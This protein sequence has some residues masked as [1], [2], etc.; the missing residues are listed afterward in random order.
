M[1]G[2]KRVR[3]AGFAYNPKTKQIYTMW[4]NMMVRCNNSNNPHYKDYGGRGIKVCKRWSKFENFLSDE[5][6]PYDAH[7]QLVGDHRK[8][9]TIDR[10]DNNGNY[11]PG[12]IRYVS[13][14]VQASNKRPSRDVFLT[15]NGKT[16]NITQWAKD[17]G[18]SH[19]NL[20]WRLKHWSIVKALSTPP[21]KL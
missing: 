20:R 8:D 21:K 13:Q 17:L 2:K 6:E 12:N 7:R 14:R 5:Y 3:D 9:M 10:I 1:S 15:Y 19:T 4:K 16:M 18:M 11:E